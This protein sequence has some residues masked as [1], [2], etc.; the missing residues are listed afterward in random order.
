MMGIRSASMSE[1]TVWD[2]IA[3]AL[4]AA[5]I[6]PCYDRLCE[7]WHV[8]AWQEHGVLGVEF[9]GSR[10]PPRDRTAAFAEAYPPHN[11]HD[12]LTTSPATWPTPGRW[13]EPLTRG[14]R[15]MAR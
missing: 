9:V 13:N 7:R 6:L 5:E 4:E 3:E 12:H 2:S 15:R 14:P 10:P 1:V 8:V 11:S